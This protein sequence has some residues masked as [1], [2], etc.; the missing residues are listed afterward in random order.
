MKTQKL[1]GILR[2]KGITYAQCAKAI[3]KTENSFQLKI[4]GKS[5]FYIDELNTL[6]DF[7]G[8]TG[9]EKAEIFLS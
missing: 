6:G 4:N 8:L 5:P 3:G 7:I 9:E 1:K 2:E